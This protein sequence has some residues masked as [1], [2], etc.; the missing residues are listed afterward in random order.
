MNNQRNNPSNVEYY[1]NGLSFFSKVC[2]QIH[3]RIGTHNINMLQKKL[4]KTESGRKHKLDEPYIFTDE[5]LYST[6][7]STPMFRFYCE[8]NKYE[9]WDDIIKAFGNKNS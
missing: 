2:K 7:I 3:Q 9:N 4:K 1:Y 8:K 6:L 5:E